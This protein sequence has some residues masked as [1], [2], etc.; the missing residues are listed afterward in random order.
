[1]SY[2]R[3][4]FA[5]V[6]C[7]FAPSGEPVWANTSGGD[8]DAVLS[9]VLRPV[10][11]D[12]TSI[13]ERRTLRL[14]IPYSPIYFSYDGEKF[15]GFAVE[16]ARELEKF[17]KQS[18]GQKIDVVL[19][20]LPRN[21]ILPAVMDGRADVAA[22]NLTITLQRLQQVAFTEP[23]FTGISELVVTGPGTERLTSFDALVASGLFLR[24]S[25]SYFAHLQTLN[26]ERKEAGQE[27]VPVLPADPR[28]EDYDLLD[29]LYAGLIPPVAVDSHKLELWS[30][31]FPGIVVQEDL[32]LNRG[33]QVGWA[34]RKD[35]SELLKLLNDFVT[36]VGPGTLVGNV[37]LERY[38]GS[39]DWIEDIRDGQGLE[40]YDRMVALI[41]KQA[42]AYGLDWKM[43]LAQAY[44]ESRLDNSQV[45]H[46]GAVGIMQVLPSTAADPK[47]N[48]SDINVLENNLEAGAKYLSFL[49]RR[50]FSGSEIAALDKIL[51]SLAAYNAGPAN[52]ARARKRAEELKL[53]PNVW[54]GN[55]ERAARRSIGAEPVTYVRNIYKYYV[56]FSLSEERD[57]QMVRLAALEEARKGSDK[58]R[59]NRLIAFLGIGSWMSG[60][61]AFGL[62][63]RRRR[64]HPVAQMH[65]SGT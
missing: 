59:K 39:P 40:D 29:M 55:V 3:A 2:L 65:G 33:G 14:A 44:Q 52:V 8:R 25:S 64:T 62:I 4:V 11:G 45:S 36:E 49:Q 38:L 46:A 9:D 35:A 18:H 1:M 13:I 47:V 42:D 54:F 56:A 57:A 31:V 21:E 19:I 6:L 41:R 50:Y 26:A 5:A 24:P 61:F 20:P 43:M 27:P 28:L 51:L 37:L 15:I 23:L 12:L 17:L 30:Q 22:A 34:V 58:Q 60:V 48:I 16:M 10:Q 63:M 32:A 7:A 53:N